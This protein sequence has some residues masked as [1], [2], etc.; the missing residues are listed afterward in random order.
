MNQSY[1]VYEE[2][3]IKDEIYENT[4]NKYFLNIKKGLGREARGTGSNP[5]PEF[6]AAVR[7]L[8]EVQRGHEARRGEEGAGPDQAL[9]DPGSSICCGFPSSSCN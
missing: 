9:Q 7:D 2:T 3:L 8:P 5:R 4:N 1:V 6:R